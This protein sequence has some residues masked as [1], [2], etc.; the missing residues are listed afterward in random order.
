MKKFLALSMMAFAMVACN[1]KQK[2]AEN[3]ADTVEVAE[4]VEVA[5]PVYVGVFKGE[6]PATVEAKSYDVTLNLSADN[7]F[8]MNM[9]PKSGKDAGKA[10]ETKGTF[11]VAGDTIKLNDESKTIYV[12][13]G[14]NKLQQLDAEKKPADKFVLDKVIDVKPQ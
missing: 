6:I 9:I 11:E 4:N 3:T 7:Q 12:L 2:T 13:Q 8:V 14:E 5:I 10:T 1:N